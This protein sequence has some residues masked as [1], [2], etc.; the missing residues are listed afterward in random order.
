METEVPSTIMV[1]VIISG[2][3]VHP[4]ASGDTSA[5]GQELLHHLGHHVDNLL[6]SGISP[7]AMN[8]ITMIP[9]G[10]IPVTLQSGNRSCKDDL[11]VYPGMSGALKSWKTARK[12]AILP[13]NYPH[14]IE[15]CD[16]EAIPHK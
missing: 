16:T 8:G 1:K 11:H 2:H 9:V 15:T 12:L 4:N 13:A 7:R 10:K 14:P 6:P 5:A 3:Q